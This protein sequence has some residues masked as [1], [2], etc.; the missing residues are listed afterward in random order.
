MLADPGSVLQIKRKD[1][2]SGY[3]FHSVTP[4]FDVRNGSHSLLT[5]AFKNIHLSFIH[6]LSF[7]DDALAAIDISVRCYSDL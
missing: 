6:E 7:L 4:H 5:Q 1:D 3:D 2:V